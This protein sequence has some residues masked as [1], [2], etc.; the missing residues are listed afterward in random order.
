MQTHLL[1]HSAANS[2]AYIVCSVLFFFFR[3]YIMYISTNKCRLVATSAGAKKERVHKLYTYRHE[4]VLISHLIW[5]ARMFDML[6]NMRTQKRCMGVITRQTHPILSKLRFI[7]L[8]F[9][10]SFHMAKGWVRT[11]KQGR[12]EH[13]VGK[14]FVSDQTSWKI[15]STT[16]ISINF[17]LCALQ[18]H[19]CSHRHNTRTPR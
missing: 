8:F 6:S 1:R 18:L 10:H 3:I 13:A 14:W 16:I 5:C 12:G 2:W 9:P 4:I 19:S 15:K 17:I 7:L 11:S